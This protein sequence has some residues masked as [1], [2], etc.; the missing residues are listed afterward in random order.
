MV[1]FTIMKTDVSE[2]RCNMYTKNSPM[3]SHNKGIGS[4]A[5]LGLAIVHLNQVTAHLILE[6]IS[7]AIK[8]DAGVSWGGSFEN[9][10]M[11]DLESIVSSFNSRGMN[12]GTMNQNM[13]C[14]LI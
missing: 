11:V 8:L 2:R 3:T 7:K 12:R 13:I 6:F 14:L 10:P 9:I 4:T 5:A 1:I